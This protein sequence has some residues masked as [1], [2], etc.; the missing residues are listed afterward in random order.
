MNRTNQKLEEIR[1]YWLSEKN[2]TSTPELLRDKMIKCIDELSSNYDKNNFPKIPSLEEVRKQ[3]P[4]ELYK[5]AV[6]L[7]YFFR[8]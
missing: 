6:Q 2:K 3:N 1:N 8:K 5:S 7:E 4:F